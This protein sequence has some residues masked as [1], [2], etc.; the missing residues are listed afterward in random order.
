[1]EAGANQRDP[2]IDLLIAADAHAQAPGCAPRDVDESPGLQD[3][4]EIVFI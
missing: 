1:M 4:V 2:M 3:L